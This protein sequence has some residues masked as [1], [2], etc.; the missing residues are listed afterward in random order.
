MPVVHPASIWQE[1]QRW[2]QVGEEM[3]RFH[4][5]S[6]RDMVLAMTHEEVV[7]D[8]LRTE[9]HSYRQL[10]L[11]IYHVQTKWRDDPR[12]RA[13]LIRT[14]EFTMLDSYSLDRDVDGLDA[15]YQAHY[16]TYFKIFHRCDLPVIAVQ[17]DVGMMG[18]MMAHEYMYLNP[19][20]EDT[21]LRCKNCGYLANS[22]V[23]QISKPSPEKEDPLPVEKIATPET[24]TIADLAEF[25]QIPKTK[26]SKAVFFK[27]TISEG[28]RT[29]EKLVFAVVRGDME[30]NET[31]LAN[32]VGA[33]S[34][35]PATDEEI[36]CSG[37][38]PG[39][40]SPIGIQDVLIVVDDLI[41]HAPNLV[42][43]ANEEGYHLRNVNYARD[44]EANCIVDLIL[45]EDNDPCP[46]CSHPMQAARGVEV[47][48]I[49]KLGT[50]YCKALDATF[51]NQDGNSV[52]IV[53]GSYGI[54]LGRLVACIAEQHHDQDGLIWPISVSP[55]HVHLVGLR[56][57]EGLAETLYQE[58]VAAE[59][60]VLY[61]D[62]EERPGVKFKDADLIGIPIRLTIS[63]R[64]LKQGGVEFKLRHEQE[65][66]ILPMDEVVAQ[67]HATI[68]QLEEVLAQKVIPTSPL[69]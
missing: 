2:Y 21:I 37:A 68:T 42:A 34:L 10:P 52:P 15:Q 57:D 16:Q 25:L 1:T 40:A 7:T 12:P 36:S 56:G 59:V 64:S 32:A 26:T 63:E 66:M 47:G 24:Y 60:E 55:Y 4:D 67:V 50:R 13:G 30:L 11:L 28:E 61:D 20:G 41:P 19:I 17:S 54:G 45:A 35:R 8:L 39:Y 65:R 31:K 22:Q 49:F 9:I 6:N 14:R 43:G 29:L 3:G 33:Q 62:R 18:G 44:Y 48:N 27:A 38:V 51:L 58:L 69:D 53:M 5:R 46:E 23:A